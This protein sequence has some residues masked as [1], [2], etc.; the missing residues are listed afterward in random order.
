[1]LESVVGIFAA[2]VNWQSWLRDLSSLL[3]ATDYR[4]NARGKDRHF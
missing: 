2:G 1:M 4:M 3:F